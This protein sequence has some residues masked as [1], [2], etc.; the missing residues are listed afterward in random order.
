M[1]LRPTITTPQGMKPEMI[2]Q[3]PKE[4]QITL[5]TF[6][7]VMQEL[8]TWVLTEEEMIACIAWWVRTFGTQTKQTPDRDPATSYRHEL[9]FRA[10]LLVSTLGWE[11]LTVVDW[12]EY[13]VDPSQDIY[14]NPTF[15]KMMLAGLR[16]AWPAIQATDIDKIATLM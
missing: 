4:Y 7:D 14:K 10:R 9:L 8:D 15:S 5:H 1:K 16:N 12:T 11:P 2:E 13:V 3:L 6:R